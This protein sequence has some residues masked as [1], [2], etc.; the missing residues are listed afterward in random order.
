MFGFGWE[1]SVVEMLESRA[2]GLKGAFGLSSVMRISSGLVIS[3]ILM[4]NGL[5]GSTVL[6]TTDEV[7]EAIADDG[8]CC[9]AGNDNGVFEVV[10]DVVAAAI[11][12]VSFIG[13]ISSV[14]VS[15]EP[16]KWMSSVGIN[17][18]L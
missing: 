5:S 18:Y 2:G 8:G 9:V 3:L 10:V 1:C 7:E 15:L 13:T 6:S 4:P 17:I 14:T 16:L 12:V 11:V